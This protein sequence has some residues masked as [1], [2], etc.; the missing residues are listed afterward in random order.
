V[1]D[2]LRPPG[3]LSAP[4]FF[5]TWLPE[6]FTRSGRRG[7][8]GAPAVRVTLSGEGGG[9]WWVRAGEDGLV[10]EALAARKT[11]EVDVWLRQ[12]AAD[13]LSTFSAGPDLPE[14]LPPGWNALD[15][16]FLDERDVA[17]LEQMSG[18]IAL[19]IAGRRRRRWTLDLS[20]AKEGVGAG[21]PRAVVQLD[22][23]TYD[24]LRTKTVAPM[25][26]LLGGKVKIEGDRSLAMKALML[27]AARLAR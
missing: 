21:R 16:L 17:L 12:S 8:A 15:L 26:A 10:V 5:E 22:A 24:G 14:L 11:I 3:D 18:R 27:V 7:A 20:F 9:D 6:A 13:F 23:A 2:P 4:A 25:Q 1:S 19:E